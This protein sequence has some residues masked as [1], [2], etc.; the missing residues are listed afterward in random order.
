MLRDKRLI[1]THETSSQG[2]TMLFNDADVA[3]SVTAIYG[4]LSGASWG[5]IG[6]IL[7]DLRAIEN[8]QGRPE[9]EAHIGAIKSG[10]A[11][12][13]RVDVIVDPELTGIGLPGEV[14]ARMGDLA[15]VGVSDDPTSTHPG[16]RQI[17][18]WP[19]TLRVKPVLDHL[20]RTQ[21]DE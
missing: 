19:I 11:I 20:A 9:F 5:L 13:A 21:A 3:A 4:S 14:V 16:T 15:T 6:A 7:N 8:T 17:V 10:E 1:K 12:W 2:R 18:L